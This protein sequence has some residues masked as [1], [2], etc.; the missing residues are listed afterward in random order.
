MDKRILLGIDQQISPA[1]QLALHTACAFLEQASSDWR[2]VLLCAIPASS[3]TSSSL[4]MY[5]GHYLPTAA[6][7]EQRGQAERAL[8][9]ARGALES[10]GVAFEQIEMQLRIGFPAEEIVKAARELRAQFII[11]GSRG[12][13]TAQNLRRFVVGSI[14]RRVL[15]L[16]PCPVMIAAL[17]KAQHPANLVTW[18]E[19][20]VAD[21]LQENTNAL[22]VFTSQEVAQKFIP[23]DKKRA[24]RKEIAAATLALEQLASNGLLCRHD[25]QG[26]LRYV[27]D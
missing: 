19:K 9:N 6:T 27:N 15:Q 22:T 17:S 5:A 11:V 16:A 25:V 14:S 10:H 1:T 21:Y 20:A 8:R 4:G 26:E 13:S 18:Y 24:G 3:A 23:P 7:P 2:V 12:N